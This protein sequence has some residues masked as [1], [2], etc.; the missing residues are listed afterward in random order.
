[1]DILERIEVGEN[2]NGYRFAVAKIPGERWIGF[3]DSDYGAFVFPSISENHI[4]G[5]AGRELAIKL[6]GAIAQS[7][8]H[9]YGGITRWFVEEELRGRPED[10]TCDECGEVACDGEC[11]YENEPGEFI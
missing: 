11:S 10:F 8:E 3:A 5:I 6:T 9:G 4:M 1:M 2:D 7:I